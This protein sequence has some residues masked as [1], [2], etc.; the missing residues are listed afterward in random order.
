MEQVTR[1]P[2]RHLRESPTNPRKAFNQAAL[3]ELADSIQ[4]RGVMQPIVVRPL[5]QSDIEAQFEVVFGHRRYRASGLAGQ[6]DVPAIVRDMSDEEVAIAQMQENVQREDMSAIEE[7]DG[8]QRLVIEHGM[9]PD[10]IAAS[11][12]KS[13]SYVYG[14]IK[15][16]KDAAPAVRQACLELGLPGEIALELAR[17]RNHKLQQQKLKEL[18]ITEHRDGEQVI[19]GWL[20]YRQAKQRLAYVAKIRL[21]SAAPFDLSDAEVLPS[22]G[23]C[24]TCPKRAGN[25]PDLHDLPAD[26]CTDQACFQSKGEA[27]AGTRLRQYQAAGYSS[28]DA[29]GAK[30]LIPSPHWDRPTGYRAL[31]DVAVRGDHGPDSHL[32]WEGALARLGP[33]APKPTVIVNPHNHQVGLWLRQD[34]CDAVLEQLGESRVE[35]GRFAREVQLMADWTPAERLAGQR[36]DGWLAVRRAVLQRMLTAPRTL[37]ELRAMAL[38]EYGLADGFGLAGDVLG[39]TA[40]AEQAQREADDHDSWSER[41]WHEAW[42]AAAP[43]DLLG[44]LLAGIAIDDQLHEHLAVHDDGARAEA[45][46]RVAMAESYGVDVLAAGGLSTPSTAAHAP[47][48]AEPA[49]GESEAA[50]APADAAAVGDGSEEQAPAAPAQE[51]TDEAGFAGGQHAGDLVDEMLA[52]APAGDEVKDDAGAV[53]AGG[54]DADEIE[55]RPAEADLLVFLRERESVPFDLIDDRL[56]RSLNVEGL[57]SIIDAADPTQDG[58][59]VPML[60]ITDAGR[61]WLAANAE[62]TQ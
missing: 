16:A 20:S 15:L 22:A 34:Q 11:M 9:T 50:R 53:G 45:A 28:I 29:D 38:R 55:L 56:G 2:L 6:P 32:T 14:R 23:A 30:K 4:A 59:V 41:A 17:L 18:S 42:I 26:V 58:K 12:G 10:Q 1:I 19:T 46:R 44:T 35:L 5:Q 7:G 61:A 13:R 8:F 51:Q 49:G 60:V 39:I 37:A 21:Q 43:A 33:D 47:E 25:D 31:D 48:E 24:T 54:Q 36:G 62:V 52:G 40:L 27:F 57:A 3:Q